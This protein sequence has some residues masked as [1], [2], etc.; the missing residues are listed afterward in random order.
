[1][2]WFS[3]YDSGGKSNLEVR[4]AKGGV[5]GAQICNTAKQFDV[6]LPVSEVSY[7]IC[8]VRIPAG[9]RLTLYVSA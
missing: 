2:M 4:V 7:R 6:V 9:V 3:S 8:S 1:M 5:R